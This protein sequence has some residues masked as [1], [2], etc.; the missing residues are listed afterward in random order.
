MAATPS[1]TGS[2]GRPS[3]TAQNKKKVVFEQEVIMTEKEKLNDEE[4]GG[5]SSSKRGIIIV[6]RFTLK[7]YTCKCGGCSVHVCTVL[8]HASSENVT[9][10]T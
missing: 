10:P 9:T 3:S 7:V 8:T 2:T 6:K 4:L 5:R 1:N